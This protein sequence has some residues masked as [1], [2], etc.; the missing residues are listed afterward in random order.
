LIDAESD[1]HRWA[2]RFDRDIGDLFT[3]QNEITRQIAVA[4]GFELIAAENA[5]PA[6]NPDAMDFILRGRT[7]HAK[8]PSRKNFGQMISNFE[9]ALALD[10][11]SVVA[12]SYLA[13]ALLGRVLNGMSDSAAADIERSEGLI[14][15]ALAISPRNPHAH[16]A[17]GFLLRA[18]P[19]RRGR[20]R[21]RSGGRVQS[22]LAAGNSHPRVVQVSDRL[23]RGRDPASRASHPPQPL[24]QP[25]RCLISADRHHPSAAIAHRRGDP[26]ARKGPQ[27][28]SSASAASSLARRGLCPQG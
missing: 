7:G 18:E 10:P 6:A 2:E 1:A 23:D 19:G 9:Q 8:P 20:S 13:T 26:L 28:R 25:A 22:R 4:L 16:L 15:R 3:V 21:I 24:R 12:N 5:K 17:K 14:N 11:R 27:L